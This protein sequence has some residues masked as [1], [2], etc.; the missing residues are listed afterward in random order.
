MG[1][2]GLRITTGVIGA[3][4]LAFIGILFMSS[5]VFAQSATQQAGN[6]VCSTKLGSVASLAFGLIELI[7]IALAAIRLATTFIKLSSSNTNSQREGRESVKGVVFSIIGMF[8]FSLF[9]AFLNQAGVVG[10]TCINFAHII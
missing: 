9:G 7:L 10:I 5:P 8:A 1:L 2:R 6:L 3:T 4:Y